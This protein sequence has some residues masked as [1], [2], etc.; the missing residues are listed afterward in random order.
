MYC[1]VSG[2]P[3]WFLLVRF[4][5]RGETPRVG[6]GGVFDPFRGAA[7]FSLFFL[8]CKR[9]NERLATP[10]FI[11]ARYRRKQARDDEDRRRTN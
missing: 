3:C 2:Q 1:T 11:Q 4:R 7:S 9:M 10:L 6:G 5:Y 8:T